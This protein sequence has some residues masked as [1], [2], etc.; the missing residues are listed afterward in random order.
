MNISLLAC[1]EI[2]KAHKAYTIIDVRS[3]AEFAH[4]HIP[5]AHNIA[6]FSDQLRALVGTRYKQHG[7]QAALQYALHEL[8]PQ[9][10]T[11]INQALAVYQDRPLCVYCARGGMRS[12]SVGWLFNL[13]KLPTVIMNG[14]YKAFRQWVT[15]QLTQT[16][17]VRLLSGKTGA[18]KTELLQ[19]LA[20]RGEP[21]INLEA[22]A[23]HKGSVFGGERCTQATQQQFENDLAFQWEA[24]DHH[25]PVWL[26]DE[27]R[28]IGAVIIPEIIWTCMQSAPLYILE[29]TRKDRLERI[30]R[31]YG[32]LNTQWLAQVT[33]VIKQQLGN[34]LH[35]QII[36]A[37]TNGAIEQA[38]DLLLTYYDRKYEHGL[39]CKKEAHRIIKPYNNIF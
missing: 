12:K 6:L 26:E 34:L 4:G 18:G 13:F 39:T 1:A 20:A 25:K 2:I 33:N 24:L 7:R 3:P 16:R 21:V 29:T 15:Q 5:G 38:A 11:L 10:C 17:P 19:T 36:H 22:L 9:F 27:S 30:L 14:G 8:G 35:T 23:R 32:S 37:L 31:E 28:K